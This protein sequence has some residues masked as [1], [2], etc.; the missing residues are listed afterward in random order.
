MESPRNRT[1]PV[2]GTSPRDREA[3]GAGDR[4]A[5]GEPAADHGASAESSTTPA[6]VLHLA[7]RFSAPFVAISADAPPALAEF[8]AR[9]ARRPMPWPATPNGPQRWPRR[10]RCGRNR[11]VPSGAGR[12]LRCSGGVVRRV[13]AD[14]LGRPTDGTPQSGA[15]WSC[16]SPASC[17]YCLASPCCT[18][19]TRFATTNT[20]WDSGRCWVHW[21][22][23]PRLRPVSRWGN[24]AR[25]RC[26]DADSRLVAV[27]AG[28]GDGSSRARETSPPELPVQL[29]HCSRDQ[30]ATARGSSRTGWVAPPGS[31]MRSEVTRTVTQS[32]GCP[33]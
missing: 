30:D 8:P 16:P 17:R 18:V 5:D 4:S 25:G 7:N 28:H 29:G 23:V 19:S 31:F 3:H 12:G 24:G 15:T 21:P 2:A 9:V 32:V 11:G 10:W 20:P 33:V 27:V 1:G 22:S 26:A 14:R 13:G 6:V